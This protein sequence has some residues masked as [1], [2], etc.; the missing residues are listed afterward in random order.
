MSK[1]E[2]ENNYLSSQLINFGNEI[3][4]EVLKEEN[5][6][7]HKFSS[8]NNNFFL[9]FSL[10]LF[11]LNSDKETKFTRENILLS[12]KSQKLTK[13]LQKNLVGISK[14]MINKIIN[15]LSGIFRECI[16]NKNGNY[17]CS[18]LIK[19]C[20][21]AQRYSILKELSNTLSE[22]CIDQY[23]THPIQNLIEIASSEEEFKLILS[24]FNDLNEVIMPSLNK[25]G[26]YVIQKI[27]IHI[28]EEIRMYFNLIFVNFICVLS[29]D[30]Y[31]VLAVKQFIYYSKNK[32][33]IN[34]FTNSIFNNFISI[35]EN[36]YGNYLIQYLLEIWWNKKEGECLKKYILSKFQ[37]LSENEYSSHICNLY[38]KLSNGIIENNQKKLKLKKDK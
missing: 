26:T 23:G 10:P 13:Q 22:D 5:N 17:F 24:S 21:K 38:T 6:Q 3:N 8:K 36:K 9:M 7:N 34:T 28:P 37:I 11:S 16:K 35:C 18:N 20:N 1:L 25:Y 4:N 15:E 31:G 12:F 19:I 2:K 27:I 30:I 32:N 14:E 29:R 33:I